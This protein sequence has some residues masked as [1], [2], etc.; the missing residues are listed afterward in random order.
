MRIQIHQE[1]LKSF[2]CETLILSGIWIL[3]FRQDHWLFASNWDLLAVLASAAG[4][5]LLFRY[6]KKI[7]S[8]NLEGTGPIL[9]RLEKRMALEEI[10]SQAE[11][12]GLWYRIHWGKHEWTR[13]C[14]PRP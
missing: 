2:G 4:I 14:D 11:P 9:L 10:Q 13:N 7:V 1:D 3:L 8:D 6:L 12:P 5:L